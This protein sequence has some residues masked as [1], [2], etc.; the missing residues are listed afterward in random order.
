MVVVVWRWWLMADEDDDGG[1][2][3]GDGGME[4]AAAVVAAD[5]DEGGGDVTAVVTVMVVLAVGGDEG[6]GGDAM[7]GVVEMVWWL[8]WPKKHSFQ[9]QQESSKAET[10]QSKPDKGKCIATGT[11]DPPVKLKK[12]SK[13]VRRD[14][15]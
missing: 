15:Q 9:S 8:R 3:E 14:P 6:D 1:E 12:A 13:E 10:G 5:E 7:R 4:M 2:V 11:E